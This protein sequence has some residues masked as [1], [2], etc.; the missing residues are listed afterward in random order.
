MPQRL[1]EPA[2]DSAGMLGLLG[3]DLRQAWRSVRHHPA[4]SLTVVIV[5]AVALA[6]N[7][8][9]FAM[10]DAIVLRPFRY[11]ACRA[12]GCRRRSQTFFSRLGHARHSWTGA[13]EHVT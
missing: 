11:P 4:L 3:Y 5:L 10:A 1:P 6:A 8:T 2:P 7:A 9:T 12:R 13:S